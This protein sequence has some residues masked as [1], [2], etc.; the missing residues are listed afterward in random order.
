MNI[1]SLRNKFDQLK[2]LVQDK[3]E[4]LVLTRNKLVDTFP[5]FEFHIPGHKVPFRKDKKKLGGRIKV[6]LRADIPCKKLNARIPEDVEALFLEINLRHTKW[7]FFGCHHPCSQN[8]GYFNQNLSNSLDL[9][10]KKYTKFFLA[11]D[12]N[13]EETETVLSEFLN[14]HD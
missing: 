14:S 4:I 3:I 1:N 13:S 2:I 9:L 11:G 7:L 8:D 12:F 6:F 5:G 10:S